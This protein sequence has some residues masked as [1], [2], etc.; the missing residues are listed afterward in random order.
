MVISRLNSPTMIG[1][2]EDENLYIYDSGNHHVRMMNA[3]SG[4]VET[5]LQG[6]CFE[7]QNRPYYI[8]YNNYK[9]SQT[10]CYKTW[11]LN[12]PYVSPDIDNCTMHKYLCNN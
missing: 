2:D 3:I 7:Y 9:L 5:L 4:V 10:I 1:V 11:L 8:P 6:A 12:G